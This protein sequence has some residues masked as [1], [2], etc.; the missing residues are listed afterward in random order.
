MISLLDQDFSQLNDFLT[1]ANAGKESQPL[2]GNEGNEGKQ[3]LTLVVKATDEAY[4]T[5]PESYAST[6]NVRGNLASAWH[7]VR[8]CTD[9]ANGT[10]KRA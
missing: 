5:Q 1:N 8:M 7:R 6:W 4:N 9:C 2:E 10:L 3:C